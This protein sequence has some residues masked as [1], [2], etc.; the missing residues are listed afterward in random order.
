MHPPPVQSSRHR[1]RKVLSRM[2]PAMGCAVE[3]LC[4]RTQC[5]RFLSCMV[6]TRCLVFV[7]PSSAQQEVV[8][9]D[10]PGMQMLAPKEGSS[11]N[12]FP[13]T[14]SFQRCRV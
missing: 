8:A 1:I 13:L 14:S 11:I 5:R 3:A 4:V 6:G 2:R 9:D 7:Y 12:T 10:G